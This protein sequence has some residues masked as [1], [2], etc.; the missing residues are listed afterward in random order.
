M[1]KY[2]IGLMLTGLADRISNN[3]GAMIPWRRKSRSSGRLAT[4]LI[5]AGVG[6]AVAVVLAQKLKE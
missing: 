2:L 4:F 1:R 6:A 5:G 3:T